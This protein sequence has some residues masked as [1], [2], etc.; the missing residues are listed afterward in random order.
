MVQF[1]LQSQQTQ[2]LAAPLGIF[3]AVAMDSFGEP[4]ITF[5][6]E[7]RKKIETLK[8][9]TNFSPADIGALGVRC[10]SQVFPVN[11]DTAR[12]R[13]SKPPS[14]C[15]IVDLPHPEGP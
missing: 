14:K 15:S 4:Q 2:N 11:N 6:G 8:H 9:K 1:V 3:A 10:S 7:R 5:S 13:R 12:C